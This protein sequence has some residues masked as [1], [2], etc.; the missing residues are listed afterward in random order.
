[1][2][3]VS[4]R[5]DHEWTPPGKTIHYREAIHLRHLHVQ[6]KNVG[7]RLAESAQSIRTIRAL[8]SDFAIRLEGK[9]PAQALAGQPFVVN[10]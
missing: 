5:E 4:R 7:A 1:V 6:K 2:F 3:I 10:D 8:A 9:E